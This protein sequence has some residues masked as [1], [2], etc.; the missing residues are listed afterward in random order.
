MRLRPRHPISLAVAFFFA[1]L[2]WYSNA[3]ERRERISER[4]LDA[5]LT[6]VNIGNDLV[7]TS[8]VP[9]GLTLRLRGP[10]SRLRSLAA[11]DVGVVVDL[12]GVGEG[13]HE[14]AVETRH[15]SVPAGVDVLAVSPSRL[16]LRLER[17]VR[18]RLP[19]QPPLSGTPAAGLV[20]GRVLTE[21]ATVLVSGPRLVLETLPGVLTDPVVVAGA[22]TTVETVVA[23]HS[24]HPL[25]RIVEPAA[26]RVAVTILPERAGRGGEGQR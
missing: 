10:L 18:R 5:P 13:D 7:I 16:P 23:L 22:T 20:V 9:L 11:A 8:E 25:V 3:L 24:P 19:V 1:A 26:V 4:Q 2:L 12:R 14:V 17:I 6:L 15:V 21:P